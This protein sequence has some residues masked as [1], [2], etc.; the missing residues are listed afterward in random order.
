MLL[1]TQLNN[2]TV[3]FSINHLFALSLNVKQFYLT[4][5]YI[6]PYQVLP[7]QAREVLGAMTMKGYSA[8]PKALALKEPHHEIS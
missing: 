2:Q 4:P 8:F 6:G 3:L 1:L 5:P 7:F